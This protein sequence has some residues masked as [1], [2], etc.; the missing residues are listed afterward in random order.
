[1]DSGLPK[2]KK[3]GIQVLTGFAS[4]LRN[5][6]GLSVALSGIQTQSMVERISRM[7]FRPAELAGSLTTQFVERFSGMIMQRHPDIAAKFAVEAAKSQEQESEGLVLSPPGQFMPVDWVEGDSQAGSASQLPSLPPGFDR[8]SVDT[9]EQNPPAPTQ[10]IMG[11]QAVVRRAGIRPVSQVEEFTGPPPKPSIPAERPKPR[12]PVPPP[13][14]PASI[15][16]QV[17][18][19]PDMPSITTAAA[20]RDQ[21]TAAAS[22]SEA[23]AGVSDSNDRLEDKPA[24]IQLASP[25]EPAEVATTAYLAT[26]NIAP[27]PAVTGS[28]D[29]V[30]A[31]KSARPAESAEGPAPAGV[32]SELAEN[33]RPA[34]TVSRS[35]D[36][37]HQLTPARP[38][39]GSLQVAGLPEPSTPRLP[40]I[41]RDTIEEIEP[42]AGT[43]QSLQTGPELPAAPESARLQHKPGSEPTESSQAPDLVLARKVQPAAPLEPE[44]PG[45]I[46]VAAQPPAAETPAK[47]SRQVEVHPERPSES[48]PTDESTK[49]PGDL[50]LTPDRP[51]DLVLSP[52]PQVIQPA[53]TEPVQMESPAVP[54]S[55]EE[56]MQPLVS[57]QNDLVLVPKSQLTQPEQMVQSENAAGTPPEISRQVDSSKAEPESSLIHAAKRSPESG[58][59]PGEPPQISTARQQ[60]DLQA[61]LAEPANGQPPD[62]VLASKPQVMKSDELPPRASSDIT[63]NRPAPEGNRPSKEA[64]DIELPPAELIAP[65]EVEA[66]PEI[67]P[68]DAKLLDETTTETAPG[69][70]QVQPAGEAFKP[71]SNVE[72][73]LSEAADQSS[74]PGLVL[75]RKVQTSPP[76]A[77]D[78]E[79]EGSMVAQKKQSTETPSSPS[80]IREGTPAERLKGPGA[81]RPEIVPQQEQTIQTRPEELAGSEIE[82]RPE[83]VLAR[84][85]QLDQPVVPDTASRED[86][87]D[88]TRSRPPETGAAPTESHAFEAAHA[89]RL[90]EIPGVQE[91]ARRVESAASREMA[92]LPAN[93]LPQTRQTTQ[94][95]D[96]SEVPSLPETRSEEQASGQP[97]DLVLAPKARPEGPQEP[98]TVQSKVDQSQIRRSLPVESTSPEIARKALADQA[99]GRLESATQP[100]ELPPAGEMDAQSH[101]IR[102]EPVSNEAASRPVVDTADTDL[103]LARKIQATSPEQPGLRSTRMDVAFQDEPAGSDQTPTVIN[104]QSEQMESSLKSVEPSGTTLPV[105]DEPISVEISRSEQILADRQEPVES[106]SSDLVLARKSQAAPLEEPGQK[107]PASSAAAELPAGGQLSQ[108]AR[109]QVEQPDAMRVLVRPDRPQISEPQKLPLAARGLAARPEEGLPGRAASSAMVPEIVKGE[110][111]LAPMI[112]ISTEISDRLSRKMITSDLQASMRYQILPTEPTGVLPQARYPAQPATDQAGEENSTAGEPAWHE[113]PPRPAFRGEKLQRRSSYD[114]TSR[115]GQLPL[116]RQAEGRK[117]D[118]DIMPGIRPVES[119]PVSPSA[120]RLPLAIQRTLDTN[121]MAVLQRVEDDEEVGPESEEEE[122]DLDVLAREVYPLIKRM[123]A[124]ERERWASR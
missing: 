6:N 86:V 22:I 8:P 28:G 9:S 121:S 73:P 89:P 116:A 7:P 11:R 110:A 70:Q 36:S 4:L 80:V 65:R 96:Q 123:L 88:L 68:T 13:E 25:D 34:S 17:S 10:T 48:T 102:R 55:Q 40:L 5:R 14:S 56:P 43:A 72:R 16:R 33:S 81:T 19:P 100:G 90:S 54:G 112:D 58:S 20:E 114:P 59:E 71:A 79:R 120:E 119:T 105:G 75:A 82:N 67:V 64:L 115:S 47:I 29:L 77:A 44:K 84:K 78:V 66:K 74:Q 85:L 118:L 1:M 106:P 109:R 113:P 2:Q 15:Q 104:R 46:S 94:T 31:R 49:Q 57:A 37:E 45:Q 98:E 21:D 41:E 103:I 108:I 62:L 69:E 99:S 63:E 111:E 83:L 53:E 27:P 24:K 42:Q 76:E 26:D 60:P 97:T 122:V 38:D 23:R 12:G 32:E 93:D 39:P 35:Q 30:L 117:E 87:P 107:T 124:I 95:S 91:I 50:S 51:A 18:S 52:K 92:D 61:K 101:Q 3:D